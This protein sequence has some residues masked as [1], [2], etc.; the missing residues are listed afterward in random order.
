MEST[1]RPI[2]S[3]SD[4]A[5]ILLQDIL[6]RNQIIII[7][8]TLR[9]FSFYLKENEISSKKQAE[10]IWIEQITEYY[11]N[12]SVILNIWQDKKSKKW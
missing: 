2:K 8:S 1:N 5:A 3:E 6:S 10:H 12:K 7:H 9:Y 4:S 11:V